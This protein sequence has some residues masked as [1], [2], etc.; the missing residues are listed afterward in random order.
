MKGEQ[1]LLSL[2][3]SAPPCADAGPR[4]R[5]EE[6]LLVALTADSYLAFRAGQKTWELRKQFA[7]R[8]IRPGRAVELRRGYRDADS[9][10]SGEIVEVV[11]AA[12]LKEFF[13]RVHWETVLPECPDEPTA[14]E[15][16]R[17]ILNLRKGANG[18]VIGMRISLQATT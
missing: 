10:I 11:S 17:H 15:T 5:P 2:E 8:D 1:L 7:E 12:S 14:I 4:A 6:R 3:W 9:A 18:P 16:A 13:Q